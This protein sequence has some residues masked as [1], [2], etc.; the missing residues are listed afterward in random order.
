MLIY[1]DEQMRIYVC[2]CVCICVYIC[3]YLHIA[4]SREC[5]K[6]LDKSKI[7]QCLPFHTTVSFGGYPIKTLLKSMGWQRI[8]LG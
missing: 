7:S 3:L 8:G 4:T 1:R 2:V 5:G 6:G